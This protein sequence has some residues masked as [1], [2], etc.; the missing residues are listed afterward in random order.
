MSCL[1]VVF[2][3][4]EFF[5]GCFSWELIFFKFVFV[6][7]FLK[8]VFVGSFLKVVFLGNEFFEG[9]FSWE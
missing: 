9:C 7:S 8:V 3:G 2:V 5:E 6:G 4:N 1:K